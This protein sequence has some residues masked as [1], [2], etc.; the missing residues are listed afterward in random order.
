MRNFEITQLQ[1]YHVSDMDM[2]GTPEYYGLLN[3]IGKWYIIKNTS[4]VFR[5]VSGISDYPTN[6]TNRAS[7]TYTTFDQAF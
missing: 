4:N 7:L 2:G 3:A 6:W 1:S 5:Y